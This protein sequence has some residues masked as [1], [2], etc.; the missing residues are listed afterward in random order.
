MTCIEVRE[1]LIDYINEDLMPDE[2]AGVE[3]HLRSCP[4]CNSEFQVL[5]QMIVCCQEPVEYQEYYVEEFV[6]QIRNRIERQRKVKNM[7]R[8]LP[9]AF[10]PL[11]IAAFLLFRQP[12]STHVPIY[13][14]NETRMMIDSLSDGQFDLLIKKVRQVSFTEEP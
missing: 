12:K 9:L 14:D 7:L 4:D 6:F 3:A 2:M 11:A 10:V 5:K 1:I 13:L 8:Y